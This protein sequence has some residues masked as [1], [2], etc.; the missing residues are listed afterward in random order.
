MCA[1]YTIIIILLLYYIII[2]L[3][4]LYYTIIIIILLSGQFP[5]QVETAVFFTLTVAV[6]MEIDVKRHYQ[7][8]D[9]NTYVWPAQ[10]TLITKKYMFKIQIMK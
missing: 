10:T 3:L 9:V 5:E 4:T 7:S 2:L 6:Y 8:I 1:H